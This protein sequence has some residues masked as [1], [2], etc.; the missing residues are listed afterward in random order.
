MG[1]LIRFLLRVVFFLAGLVVALSLLVA[2]V[3]VAMLWGL[4]MLWARVTGKP[5]TPFMPFVM[6][7]DPRAG[8][9]RFNDRGTTPDA[10][11][12]PSGAE[13][14]AARAV[15]GGRVKPDVEDVEVRER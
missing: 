14:A 6:R 15:A 3:I 9:R 2:A 7:V 5:V 11:P 13:R 4:R 12:E 10:P 8:W 1:G